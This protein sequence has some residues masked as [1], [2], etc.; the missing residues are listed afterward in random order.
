MRAG[1]GY[2]YSSESNTPKTFH[3]PSTAS[4]MNGVMAP[5]DTIG[6]R[7]TADVHKYPNTMALTSIVLQDNIELQEGIIEI[8]AFAGEEC[9]GTIKMTYVPEEL[10]HPY[11]GFLLV[12]GENNEKITFKIYDHTTG[13]EYTAQQQMNFVADAMHGTLTQPYILSFNTPLGIEDTHTNTTAGIALYPN[14]VTDLLHIN[15]DTD[16]IDFI[17]LTDVVGRIILS[18][19]NFVGNTINM[20][21][22]SQGIYFL[23]ATAN[24]QTTTHK[25]IKK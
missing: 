1:E 6:Y 3:Y 13:E 19:Q 10:G 9:R 15:Y 21:S 8:A 17:E 12:Y 18:E 16:K 11:I 4:Q 23:K 25:V 20:T 5:P 14:P 24:G 7:W 22:L 2:I